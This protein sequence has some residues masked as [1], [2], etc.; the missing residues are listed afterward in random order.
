M[1]NKSGEKSEE[2]SG[3]KRYVLDGTAVLSVLFRESSADQIEPFLAGA[4]VSAVNYLEILIT[5]GDRGLEQGEAQ[6]MLSL[7]DMEVIP[8]DSRQAERAAV[9]RHVCIP[10]Y[11]LSLAACATL[12]LAHTYDAIA[13]TTDPAWFGLDVGYEIQVKI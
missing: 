7:L 9:L 2:K 10:A 1:A 11:N 12:A 3:K 4:M 13:I 6:T 8:F 5:L